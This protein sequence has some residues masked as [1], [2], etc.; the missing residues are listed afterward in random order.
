MFK[1]K[2]KT[3]QIMFEVAISLIPAVLYKVYMYGFIAVFALLTILITC[4]VTEIIAGKVLKIK[5]NILDFSSIVSALILFIALNPN[6]P[7]GVYIIASIICIGL[8][9][10]VYGGL[11]KNIF[12][13]AMVAWCFIMISFP[14]YMTKFAHVDIP[15]TLNHAY[16]IFMGIGSI[17]SIDS[18]DSIS[19]AT[20]LGI[21]KD[22]HAI[23]I[24][25]QIA[26]LNL[27][28][29]LGGIYLFIRSIVSY[30]FPLFLTLGTILAIYIFDGKQAMELFFFAGPFTL[31]AF[32]II[33]DP[34]SSPNFKPA[35]AIYSFCI[36]F[37]SILIAYKGA[38]PV[39]VAFATLIM[40]S[41]VFLLDK[42]FR[43]KD[44]NNAN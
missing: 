15:V 16:S 3:Q 12:N 8:G 4:I 28:I 41:F 32:Y 1:F 42:P 31:A 33:T 25:L 38:Y 9:K 13:P 43:K 10:M 40:N 17:D 27:L 30:I 23:N 18:I 2:T 29:L 11:G 7:I 44:I 34:T 22:Q 39:G 26:E 5:S 35:Q 20:P 24:P 21:Y 36:G 6:M 37:L 19:Q 14:Q